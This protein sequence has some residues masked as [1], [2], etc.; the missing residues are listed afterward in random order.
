MMAVVHDGKEFNLR[1]SLTE[2]VSVLDQTS[3][4]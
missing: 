2:G 4:N 3:A 1:G